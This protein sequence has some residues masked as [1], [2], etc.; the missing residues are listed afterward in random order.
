[1]Y[2]SF[3]L[4]LLLFLLN[5][6][7]VEYCITSKYR[8]EPHLILLKYICVFNTRTYT[9]LLT[10]YGLIY[11]VNVIISHLIFKKTSDLSIKST[12]SKDQLLQCC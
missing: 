12:F 4:L 3:S 5:K 7:T 1:M 11:V 6:K 9:S 2:V 10:L 8:Y